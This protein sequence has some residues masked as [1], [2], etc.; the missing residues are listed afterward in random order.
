MQPKPKR[1]DIQKPLTDSQKQ[2]REKAATSGLLA[3]S[4]ELSDLMDSSPS[5]AA[6][7]GKKINRSA[8]SGA[9]ATIDTGVLAAT[10]TST[11]A[12]PSIT[13][14]QNSPTTISSSKLTEQ[15]RVDIAQVLATGEGGS[16][17][18]AAAAAEKPAATSNET[19]PSKAGPVSYSRSQED[20][21]FVMD[22]NKGRLHS[23]YRQARRSNPGL[24]GKIVFDITIL[25][26]GEVAEVIIRSSEL[27]NPRLESRLVSRIKNFDFGER[28]GDS[29]TVTYPV[30]FLPS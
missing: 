13:I 25:P 7:A 24:K 5:A 22:R 16:A 1:P 12:A 20:I 9:A 11:G 26:S 4:S 29:I 17:T 15:A 14:A 2:A 28:E 27:N 6:I 8:D 18:A 30:E 10:T 19:A 3:L 23:V 21:A